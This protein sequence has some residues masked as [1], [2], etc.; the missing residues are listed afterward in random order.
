MTDDLQPVLDPERLYMTWDRLVCGK[1]FCAGMT[2]RYTGFDI[3]GHEVLP[4]DNVEAALY[5]REGLTPVCECGKTTWDPAANR[6]VPTE[7]REDEA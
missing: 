7:S 2:A 3:D 6:A 5:A 1:K 4:F